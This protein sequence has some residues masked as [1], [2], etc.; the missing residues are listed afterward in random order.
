MQI[1]PLSKQRRETKRV[2]SERAPQAKY[3]ALQHDYST[4]CFLTPGACGLT[5]LLKVKF[6]KLKKLFIQTQQSTKCKRSKVA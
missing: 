6:T 3:Q 4:V 1:V 2:K 5:F